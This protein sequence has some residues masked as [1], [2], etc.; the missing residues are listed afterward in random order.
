MVMVKLHHIV[1]VMN[2]RIQ[3]RWEIISM[4]LYH[5]VETAECVVKTLLNL[6]RQVANKSKHVW[7]K[8]CCVERGKTRLNVCGPRDA[9]GEGMQSTNSHGEIEIN[10]QDHELSLKIIQSSNIA[11]S[12]KIIQSSKIVQSS[13]II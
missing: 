4:V 1:D 6:L 9:A 11:K 8:G 10:S 3:H 7:T 2:I 5:N 13:K 12:L